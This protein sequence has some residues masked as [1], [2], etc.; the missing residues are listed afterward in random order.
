MGRNFKVL[1]VYDKM[2]PATHNFR[3]EANGTSGTDIEFVDTASIPSGMRCQ[4]ISNLGDHKKVLELYDH[5]QATKIDITHDFDAQTDGDIELWVRSDTVNV[6]TLVIGLRES[7]TQRTWMYLMSSKWQYYD[8]AVKD[9]PNVGTPSVDTWHHIRIHFDCGT[10]KVTYYIDGISSGEL[11][12]FNNATNIDNIIISTGTNNPNPVLLYIDAFGESWDANY[13]I[14]DNVHWRHYKESTD[15]FEGDDVG[16]QGTDITWVDGVDTAAS[17]EIVAEFNAHKKILRQDYTSAAGGH[18]HSYHAFA[19]QAT[20]GW[21]ATWIKVSDV[22]ADQNIQLTEDNTVIII[23]RI[24]NSK[25]Q[26]FTAGAYADIGLAAVNDTQYLLFVQWHADNTFDVWIDNV[27]YQ[28]GIATANNQVSGINRI[29]VYQLTADKYIYLDAPI[30]S[31]DGDSRGDNRTFDYNDTYTKKDITDDVK[32]IVQTNKLYHW[33]TATMFAVKQYLKSEV[34]IQ[35]YD[36]TGKLGG[37]FNIQSDFYNGASYTHV[38]RDKNAPDLKKKSSNDFNTKKIHDP[39]D[40]TCMLK[41]VLPNVGHEDGRLL[42]VNADT[43]N[44]T[45]SPTTKNYPDA[46]F[47]HDLSNLANS[48]VIIEPSG[49]VDLDDDKSSGDALDV[50]SDQEYFVSIPLI[51]NIQ[52]DINYFDVYGAID[53]DTGTRIHKNIDNSGGGEKHPWSITNNNLTSWSD[54]E[55]FATAVSTRIV[56]IKQIHCEFT[57]LQAHSMGETLNLTYDD[58]THDIAATD[59]YIISEE[60]NYDRT[61]SICILSEGLIEESDFAQKYERYW[62]ETNSQAEYILNRYGPY[63]YAAKTE[64]E[65]KNSLDAIGNNYGI[66]RISGTITLTSKVS[67]TGTGSYIIEGDGIGSLI[68]C[69]GD[70]EVFDVTGAC[71]ITFRNFKIDANDLTNNATSVIAINNGNATVLCDDIEIT[72][73]GTHGYGIY[74]ASAKISKIRDCRIDSV[75]NGIRLAT[76][77]S[78]ATNNTVHD[79]SNAG[80]IITAWYTVINNNNCNNNSTGISL[81]GDYCV[82]NG[83]NCNNNTYQN[84]LITA[85]AD[86]NV[87]S[88]NNCSHS[89]QNHDANVEGISCAG[90]YCTIIGN[91]CN[92]NTNAGTGT[93]YGIRMVGDNSTIVGN[94]CKNNDNNLTDGGAGNTTANNET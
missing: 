74:I 65:L 28:A 4:I 83:N 43:E 25:F 76:T 13:N 17:V 30:S 58:A 94:T 11:D 6:Q 38:L 40:D 82:V 64:D 15:S 85:G 45:Y 24:E 56:D 9:I 22:T 48:T 39:S 26:L 20:S 89:A 44:D 60:Y 69:G 52:A 88:G 80:I 41:T 32:N 47:L 91:V 75:Y 61:K 34:F 3:D 33:R 5:V 27:R 8:G 46:L 2:Y 68:D 63:Y 70:N 37:E 92:G 84:M 59:F 50:D 81:S 93:G 10:D 7:T 42:L 79:C 54:V 1:A 53:P 51:S 23:I 78:I 73:D 18:D 90:D 36:I 87:I 35:A 77:N 19:T 21:F 67:I 72:G 16:T 14:G 49:K 86:N 62:E 55:D 57:G 12:F 29:Y 31:L 71:D 66:I